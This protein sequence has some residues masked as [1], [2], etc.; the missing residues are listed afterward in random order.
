MD[1]NSHPR[2]L[3]I[4]DHDILRVM[5]FT[6]LRHQALQVDTAISAD[7][8]LEKVQTCDYALIL[9]D[10]NLENGDAGSFLTRFRE[11]RPE[12]TTF[13]IAVR[14]PNKETNGRRRGRLG[15]VEQAA[16]DR[17]ARRNRSRMRD[18]RSAAG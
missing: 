3:I 4:E 16:G 7:A 6:I 15:G 12:A 11:A 1:N 5:L 9:I 10:M 13:V 18:R 2:V 14:D 8:A 17:H